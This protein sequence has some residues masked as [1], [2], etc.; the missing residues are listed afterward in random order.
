MLS[1]TESEIFQA[2]SPQTGS[3]QAGSSQSSPEDNTLSQAES[4]LSQAGSSQA[5][6]ADSTLYMAESDISQVSQASQEDNTLS[7][8]QSELSPAS[9]HSSLEEGTLQAES[10]SPPKAV[11]HLARLRDRKAGTFPREVSEVSQ[12][13]STV[14]QRILP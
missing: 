14:P 11:R 9:S 8:M 5:S 10:S 13:N 4:V 7:P 6:L 3:S 2:G 1:L 12:G